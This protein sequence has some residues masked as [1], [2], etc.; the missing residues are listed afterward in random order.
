MGCLRNIYHR[1]GSR[2]FVPPGLPRPPGRRRVKRAQ[3]AA[4][5]GLGA[6]EG[7]AAHQAAFQAESLMSSSDIQSTCVG[8][9]LRAEL[10]GLRNWGRGGAVKTNLEKS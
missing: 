5:W 2:R 9:L 4:T 6:P 8:G 10:G 1:A 7:E 3:A